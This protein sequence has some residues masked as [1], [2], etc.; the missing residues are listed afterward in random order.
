[1]KWICARSHFP[2]TQGQGPGDILWSV[3]G[4]VE[5]VWIIPFLQARL[6]M[7]RGCSFASCLGREALE[8]H[9]SLSYVLNLQR[10]LGQ[11]LPL[12]SSWGESAMWHPWDWEQL[13]D[14]WFWETSDA[15]VSS[16]RQEGRRMQGKDNVCPFPF[17]ACFWK[18]YVTSAYI[19]SPRI[20]LTT[21]PP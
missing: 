17:K 5:A 21:W 7:R 4:S 10:V 19:S 6:G 14:V 8:G 11:Q 2:R 13:G 3:I 16:T 9:S 20:C 18:A 12:V 1:M 15:S